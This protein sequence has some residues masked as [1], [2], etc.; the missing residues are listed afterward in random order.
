MTDYQHWKPERDEQN[1]L[2]LGI[3]K[4]DAGANVLSGPVL[5]EL[6]ALLTESQ[7]DLPAAVIVHSL[8]RSGF[9]MGADI[10]EFT[11]IK[12]EDEAY[13]L[14]RLGQTV[15]DRLE[16]FPAPTV[17]AI[18]GFALGGGLELAMACH[19][20]VAIDG[21]KPCIGLPEVKLGIHPGFG[22]TV[23][24]VRLAGVA[25][26]M[27]LMLTG[28]SITPAKAK[29]LGLVDA[30]CSKEEWRE[31]CIRIANEQPA[32]AR[33][34]LTARLMNLP[35][36]R[37]FIANKIRQQ[38]AQKANKAHYPAPFAII[39]LFADHG[40]SERSGYDA[41]AR[42]IA[43]LMVGETARNLVRVFFLQNALKSQ[44]RKTEQA[45][46]HVHVVGA[47][48]MGGDIA[49]WCALKGLQVTLQDRAMEYVTPA[50]ERAHK[51]YAKKVRND[52][53]RAATIARLQADVEG[54]GVTKADLIIEAI[55]ENL[56]AK[57]A[58]YNDLLPNV[59]DAA[60]LAT[61]TSSI[62]IEELRE[63]LPNPE[64]FIGLHF[65]NPV[66]QLPLVEVIQ[67]EGTDPDVVNT[68][69]AFVKKIGKSPLLCQ[70]APG[71]V[72]NRILAPY[73]GEAFR[74]AEEGVALPV[75]DQAALDFGMPMGPVE[76]ADSVGLDVALSAAR[77][78]GSKDEDMTRLIAMVEAGTLGRKSGQGFYRWQD[79]RAV[80]P[81]AGH[82][83]APA[84]L[85]DR[86]ILP[87]VNEAVDVLADGVVATEELL[88]AG[89]IFG[90]GFAPFRGGPLHYCRA[91]GV[92]AVCERLTALANEH[93]SRFTPKAASWI[94]FTGNG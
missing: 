53:D 58:L 73:M 88:D 61:N 70:S 59:K 66:A 28:K 39:D 12:T 29:K 4:A 36:V 30:L 22:G 1:R 77:V 48:V 69:L 65:F 86:L 84:D 87:M 51:L 8:K 64:R 68:G 41:E 27:P 19:Y 49:A 10:N 3:D 35:V 90:T 38:T 94:K 9:I 79:G 20:R 2:W 40:A 15:L 67:A 78:L 76:L 42:S 45:I 23:R 60:I 55:Y 14:I 21:G 91:R 43:K 56:E 46:E 44:G 93:G 47:G 25:Q 13:D 6:D 83:D 16:Q 52:T 5:R 72:V 26:A 62:R 7:E 34:P 81:E 37:G 57:Q 11:V 31:A 54:A 82:S 18:D 63:T 75:I 92:D 89:V 85:T 80:K 24:A 50:I 32:R 17:A 71:F 33:A 74:L